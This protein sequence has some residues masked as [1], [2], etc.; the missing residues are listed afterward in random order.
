MCR[1]AGPVCAG[2]CGSKVG[3]RVGVQHGQNSRA[4]DEDNGEAQNVHSP[5][6]TIVAMPHCAPGCVSV[7][8]RTKSNVDHLASDQKL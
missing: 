6:A 4:Q 7:S 2:E 8:I 5:S 3:A 1:K